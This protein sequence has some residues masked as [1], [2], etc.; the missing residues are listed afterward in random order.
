MFCFYKICL[1]NLVR[2]DRHDFK[3]ISPE[4]AQFHTS[5]LLDVSLLLNV[6]YIRLGYSQTPALN[7]FYAFRTLFDRF[8]QVIY[9][10]F[11]WVIIFVF[12]FWKA[13]G[14]LL[15]AHLHLLG[16]N[17]IKLRGC[18]KKQKHENPRNINK[19]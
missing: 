15:R 13:I 6:V 14:L 8:Y 19:T 3:M 11:I 5:S 9:L 17:Y 18:F 10:P 4:R 12:V 1:I 2:L 7:T 16:I